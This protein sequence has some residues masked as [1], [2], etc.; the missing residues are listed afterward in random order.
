[1]QKVDC[2]DKAFVFHLCRTNLA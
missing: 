2:G 1:M